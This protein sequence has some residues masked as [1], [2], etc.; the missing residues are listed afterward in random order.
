[1]EEGGEE[2]R[3][4][5]D[6]SHGA[7]RERLLRALPGTGT[8]EGKIGG[9]GGEWLIGETEILVAEEDEEAAVGSAGMK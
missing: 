3:R 9:G 8:W 5:E 7:A 4:R 6:Q 2:R 1:M